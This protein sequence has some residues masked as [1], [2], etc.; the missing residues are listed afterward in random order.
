MM[1]VDRC[2]W[3][4]HHCSCP[5]ARVCLPCLRQ[6]LCA[7]ST[8]LAFTCCQTGGLDTL[9]AFCYQGHALG[10]VP[11]SFSLYW[12]GI[13]P[14]IWCSTR[15]CSGDPSGGSHPAMQ[16]HLDL[17]LLWQLPK[18]NVLLKRSR[19]HPHSSS[20]RHRCSADTS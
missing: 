2:S 14:R 8:I 19:D 16:T 1:P 9:P 7:S 11:S 4:L 12:S 20:C 3:G 17:K 10:S 6:P 13:L 15:D 5:A 18:R